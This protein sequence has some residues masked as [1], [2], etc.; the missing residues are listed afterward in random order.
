ML[1]FIRPLKKSAFISLLGLCSL[2]PA[3][4]ASASL[5]HRR[6]HKKSAA[7]ASPAANASTTAQSK[8]PLGHA[9]QGASK[10]GGDDA[11]KTNAPAPPPAEHADEAKTYTPMRMPPVE[12][13]GEYNGD[14]RDLP[15]VPS[16]QLLEPELREPRKNV[17]GG[18][19]ERPL[20]AVG[21][22]AAP[23]PQLSLSF[24]GMSYADNYCQGGRCGNGHPPDTTG[25]IGSHHYIQAINTAF[26]IYDKSGNR[27]AAFT[28]ASLWSGVGSTACATAPEGDPVVVYDQ[29]FDR[30]ILSNFAFVSADFGPFYECFA[31]SKTSDPVSGGWYFYAVRTDQGQVPLNTLDDYPK[32]GLWNDGC[33]YMGANGFNGSNYNGQIFFSINRS[34]MYNGASAN[35]TL[36]FLAGGANFGLNPATMLGNGAG[37]PSPSTPA[38]FVQESGTDYAFNVR[39][40]TAD[41][42]DHPG[43]ISNAFV[44]PQAQYDVPDSDIVPQPATFNKLDSLGDRLMQWVQYRK[45]GSAESLWV[46]HTTFFSNENTSPQWAQIDVTGGVIHTTAVQQQI[47][48]LDQ[49]LYR[50][51]GSLAVDKL[52]NMALCYSTSNATAPNYPS[53]ACAGRLVSDPLSQLPQGET[54]YVAGQGSQTSPDRWGDYSST[55]VDPVDDCTFWHTNLFYNSQ[56]NGNVANYQSQILAFHYPNCGSIQQFTLT[57]SDNGQGTINSTDGTINCGSQCSFNYNSGTQ[58]T[59]NA[60]AAPGWAFSG[61]SG[62]CSGMGQCV[63]V[64]TQNQSVTANFTQ[65]PVTLTVSVVGSGTVTSNDGF[66]NCPGTCSHTYNPGSQLTLSAT[67]A[68]GWRFSGWTGACIGVSPCTLV[69][70]NNF[71]VTGVFV[72]P[73]HGLQFNALAPCRV[74]DTRQSGPIQG[75]TAQS[76]TL[77]QLGC[78]IPAGALAYSV[79]VTAVPRAGRLGF[80]TIWPSGEAQPSVSTLNSPDGRTKAN[81]A[82]VPAGSQGAV[83]VYV[84]NTTDVILDINGYFSTPAQGTLQFFPL[85]PCRIV[86][87]RNGNQ[88]GSLQ[89]GMER[90]YTIGG[91]CGI[92]TGAAAYSLN[93]TVLPT[94][95]SLDYLTVWPQGT[96]QPV[97]S[98]LNDSTGTVVANAAIV[99][100]GNNHATAFYAHN[101]NIDLLV[102]TNGYFAAPGTGGSSF[103]AP[104]PCRVYDS[105]NVGNGQPFQGTRVVSVVGSPCAPPSN[106]NAFVFGATVLPANGPL[107]FL[108]L[109]P[110]SQLQ[111]TVSTLNARDGLITS[112]MAIVPNADGSIDAFASAL[113]QLILDISGYFAP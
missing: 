9:P 5:W 27:L 12:L 34:Q 37:L 76:F 56:A 102:D 93:V 29:V 105:R 40:W 24:P 74:V 92:P 19:I 73:G 22:P 97:V 72:Q 10:Q 84:T 107:G 104:A 66:I 68:Q 23:M 67:A 50:W 58:V 113:T 2:L 75:G 88:G 79:N 30:W 31:V 108:T 111:P 90:D 38:Y 48:Q 41:S 71:A 6:E 94:Q 62:A 98:T 101:H 86:D 7:Q 28:E 96:T 99:P 1:Q 112:N 26:A 11:S 109:W 17:Q 110:D 3:T 95:G 89:A 54:E 21:P 77:P 87:T 82:I 36:A 65:L 103:Y 61:W 8:Q 81:A 51:M 63:V 42:C 59:L 44:I 20:I 85:T 64:M 25:A 91:A 55:T 60:T 83:S 13:A 57:V 100:A 35:N 43:N 45:V 32:L 16:P 47:Y 18:P 53:L 14:V 4:P 33:L 49:T 69:M 46:N 15:Q 78:G 80:L 70:T 39:T 52:G 106:A